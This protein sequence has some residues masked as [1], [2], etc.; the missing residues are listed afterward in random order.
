MARSLHEQSLALLREVGHRGG[1]AEALGILASVAC[2]QGDYQAAR[3]L[4]RQSLTTR[5]EIGDRFGIAV[6]LAGLGELALRYEGEG[7]KK[8]SASSSPSYLKAKAGATLLGAAESL[9]ESIGAALIAD[10]RTVYERGV[11]LAREMLDQ[12]AFARAR[13]EGRTVTLEEAIALAETLA[14]NLE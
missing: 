6:C 3:S 11:T 2:A 8:A 14:E 7:A 10:L 1:I 4:Y 12:A 9:A 13:D 5:R